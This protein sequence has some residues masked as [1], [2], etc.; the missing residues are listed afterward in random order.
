M[1]QNEPR[2]QTDV[3]DAHIATAPQT[4]PAMNATHSSSE[5]DMRMEGK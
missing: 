3:V 5:E 4:M 1:Q 2:R